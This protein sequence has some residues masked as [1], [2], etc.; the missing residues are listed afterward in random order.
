MKSPYNIKIEKLWSSVYFNELP[1]SVQ[2]IDL[3]TICDK[4]P[5]LFDA[6]KSSIPIERSIGRSNI[7]SNIPCL[8]MLNETAGGKRKSRRHRQL[9]HR[10]N[11]NKKQRKTKKN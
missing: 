4:N 2:N 7:Q 10:K 11:R 6:I 1:L 9:K 3:S 5:Q 8:F